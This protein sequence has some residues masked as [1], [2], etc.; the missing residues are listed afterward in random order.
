VALTS[1]TSSCRSSTDGSRLISTA[2]ASTGSSCEGPLP[3]GRGRSRGTRRAGQPVRFSGARCPRCPHPARPLPRPASPPPR[4]IRLLTCSRS[5]ARPG[6]PRSRD[7]RHSK[8]CPQIIDLRAERPW[9][10]AFPGAPTHG[11][12][13][14]KSHHRGS[15]YP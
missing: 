11:L 3:A 5:F 7:R 6:L 14:A 1:A 9:G 10:P 8:A 15:L 2:I 4:P 12:I 13:C